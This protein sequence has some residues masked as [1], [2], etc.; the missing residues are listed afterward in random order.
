M[1][2]SEKIIKREENFSKWYTSVIKV[3][4]IVDYGLIKGT[5]IL[6]PYGFQIWENI[7]NSIDILFKEHEIQNC[8]LPTLIPYSEFIKEKSHINGFAPELFKITQLGNDQLDDPYVL[9]PTSEISFCHYF[10]DNIQNHNDL[11][12]KLNQWC[13]VFRVEKNTKPFLRTS[14]FFWQEQHAVFT[15][16]VESNAF[17]EKMIILYKNFLKDYLA[18]PSIFGKKTE[19]EKFPGALTTHTVETMM[20]DGQALQSATSHD[21]GTIFSVPFNIKYQ[22]KDNKY[23]NVHQTSA[24]ISSRII[25]G[26]IMVHG[27]DKGLVLPP[28][29]AP[30]QV[31]INALFSIKNPK[32]LDVCNKIKKTLNHIRVSIDAT[33]KNFGFKMFDGETKG[34]PIQINIGPKT[35]EKNEAEIVIRNRVEKINVSLNKI[36]EKFIEKMLN[37]YHHELYN[38]S[39]KFLESKIVEI[40]HIDEFDKVIKKGNFILAFWAGS[41]SD[42]EK[43][44]KST[45]ATSRCL[46]DSSEIGKCFFTG[47]ETKTKAYFARAY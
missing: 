2:Q 47:K 7:K 41:Q 34:I 12:M 23:Q 35:L 31:K 21:L 45:G 13:S 17:A 46:I 11:P 4:N 40:K 28:K 6:K 29:I 26:I 14:E 16:A 18:I 20:Q 39:L 44:K 15:N 5:I 24:G 33:D 27:D 8:A 1:K 19:F 42:E 22:D 37:D 3:S 10:K 38:K 9:R 32:V 43:I 36:D 30:I 25:G